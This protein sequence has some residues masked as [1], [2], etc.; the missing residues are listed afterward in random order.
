M[1]FLF[2]PPNETCATC[3]RYEITKERKEAEKKQNKEA[4][5]IALTLDSAR[6]VR[7]P[8][9]QDNGDGVEGES[10]GGGGSEQEPSNR[11]NLIQSV[12]I[13]IEWHVPFTVRRI[14]ANEVIVIYRVGKLEGEYHLLERGG[15]EG[16]ARADI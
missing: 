4:G 15:E 10:D 7:P 3:G 6:C 9:Q 12:D 1:A 16:E 5:K 8:P 11:V 13:V 2:F 14:F